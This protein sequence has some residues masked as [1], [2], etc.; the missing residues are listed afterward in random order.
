MRAL[1]LIATLVA[2]EHTAAG[3]NWVRMADLPGTPRDDGAAFSMN[4]KV[5]VG[6][7]RDVSFALTNDWFAYSEGSD[8]WASIAPLPATGRQYCTAFTDGTHGY[9][10]G[11]ID[12]NGPL[13]E[14][15]RYDPDTDLWEQM[16]SLPGPGR[17]ASVVLSDRFIATGL[18]ADGTATSE[19]W[20]YDSGSDEWTLRADVPG[21]PRHRASG[22]WSLIGG[23]D[24]SY[25]AL[26]DCYEYDVFNGTWSPLQ[27]L[28]EPRYGG[29]A[30]QNILVGGASSETMLHGDVRAYGDG[31][32]SDS[33]ILEPFPP[34]MRRGG[35]IAGSTVQ[36][37]P[38]FYYGT[39]VDLVQRHSDWWAFHASPTSIDDHHR[40]TLSIAPVPAMNE[41]TIRM[42]DNE[43]VLGAVLYDAQGQLALEWTGAQG[44]TIPIHDLRPGLYVVRVWTE[45]SIHRTSIIKH[46]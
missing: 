5:Y 20:E 44:G 3:Q 12:V 30:F 15:W 2:G 46:P 27:D 21:T 10:F 19:C 24:A 25:E 1:L 28:P 4:G 33:G 26:S 13:N 40:S 8:T 16:T 9:L 14:L 41:I 23:A 34:G 17:Y 22:G 37:G 45:R 39:G 11:G 32:W 42:A 43:V 36:N 38:T 31:A 18:L 29:D 7:G 6:T 35:V